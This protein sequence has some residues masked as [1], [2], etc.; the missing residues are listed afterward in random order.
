[1]RKQPTGLRPSRFPFLR[2]KVTGFSNAEEDAVGIGV[3]L[4]ALVENALNQA[5]GLYSSATQIF[6]AHTVRSGQILTGQNPQ[7]SEQLA[8]NVVAALSKQREA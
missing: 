2:E 8:H 3:E 1:M 6:T 5:G 7:S 4:P